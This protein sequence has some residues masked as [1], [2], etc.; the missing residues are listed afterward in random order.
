MADLIATDLTRGPE[1][2]WYAG[3]VIAQETTTGTLA[4]A[5]Y[6]LAKT[7]DYGLL[8][9]VADGVQINYTSTGSET[10]GMDQITVAAGVAD[11]AV[12]DIYYVDTETTG[13]T[14]ISSAEDFKSSSKADTEKKSV[15]GQKNKINIVGTT[16]HSGSF[17]QLMVTKELKELFVG[18]TTTG[19]KSGEGVWS[20][21]V[22]AFHKVGCLVGKKYNELGTIT[23]KWGLMGV[24]FNS[25]DQD[26]PVTGVYTDSFNVDID[27][28]LE[29]G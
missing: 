6:T 10:A 16:E 13:L 3:G 26:F 20:N 17:S 5:G 7:A 19:P 1:V 29:W 23:K 11:A 8:I 28:L 15:H 2:R 22:S 24:S 12:V 9:V 21:K 25:H 4:K 18:S 14:H 27:W